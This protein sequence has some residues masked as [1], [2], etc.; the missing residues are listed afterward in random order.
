[1]GEIALLG[2]AI[3]D[4]DED[5]VALVALDIL[6]IL[7]EEGLSAPAQ[8]ICLDVRVLAT[9]QLELFQDPRT[10]RDREGR[11]PERLPGQFAGVA[12]T[13]LGNMPRLRTLRPRTA[14]VSLVFHPEFEMTP[15]P[16]DRLYTP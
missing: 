11:N 2:L 9:Q 7:D 10:L 4:R 16:R 8:T 13:C 12:D 6:Q 14:T 3:A 15:T 1:M 5:D